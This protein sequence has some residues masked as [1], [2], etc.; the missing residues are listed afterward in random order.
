VTV[1][2]RA[3]AAMIRHESGTRPLGYSFTLRIT[4]MI[5]IVDLLATLLLVFSS[6]VAVVGPHTCSDVLRAHSSVCR[7]A[8]GVPV[9]YRPVSSRLLRWRSLVA[10]VRVGSQHRLGT[11]L[12][13]LRRRL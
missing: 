12:P 2:A 9:G 10:I 5:T 3:V 7:C 11:R 8:V 13:V 6:P 4:K 1:R